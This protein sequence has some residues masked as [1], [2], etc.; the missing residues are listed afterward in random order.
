MPMT[1]DNPL[2]PSPTR[3]R[4]SP[5]GL[6]VVLALAGLEIACG[7]DFT[8][9]PEGDLATS[10][11]SG[12]GDPSSSTAGIS[13]VTGQTGDESE[14]EGDARPPGDAP[15]VIAAFTI[16]GAAGPVTVDHAHTATLEVSAVD[17]EAIARVRLYEGDVALAVVDA[18]PY[19][20]EWAID[21]ITAAA[22]RT[23]RAIAED[24]RGQASAPAEIEVDFSM[25]TPG[26]DRWRDLLGSLHAGE[27][28]GLVRSGHQ[29]IAVGARGFDPQAAE[30][31]AFLRFY[32]ADTGAM[33]GSAAYPKPGT[34]ATYRANAAV[35]TG[36]GEIAVVG[37]GTP[38]EEATRPWLAVFAPNGALL[39]E[40]LDPVAGGEA[41]A[42][43]ADAG[44]L[45]V[46]GQ[47]GDG[48][49]F[50]RRHDL[51][52]APSWAI[53]DDD[54]THLSSELRGLVRGDDGD[55]YVAGT[56]LGAA[57][58]PRVFAGRYGADGS[59][60]WSGRIECE[61]VESD[62]GRAIALGDEG[63]VLIAAAMATDAGDRIELRWIDAA[64]GEH[65]GVSLLPSPLTLGDEVPNAVVVDRRG[66]VYVSATTSSGDGADA[67][68]Y[69]RS[70]DG[71]AS[72]WERS[73]DGADHSDDQALALAVGDDGVVYVG[74]SL[75]TAGWRR[76]WVQALEP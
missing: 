69:K 2:A 43:V 35:L 18:P 41:H 7:P 60:R 54:P 12:D 36:A 40:R 32:D 46:A 72:M 65:R 47:G 9:D 63:D 44:G 10:S 55:L 39:R 31:H 51:D 37:V 59:V 4:R 62:Q 42:V 50:L 27:V 76:W 53:G 17:D 71:G 70:T 13:T 33:T 56:V 29:L 68:V 5:R 74:G 14:S 49:L 64:A 58:P 3:S 66:R 8:G 23:L 16:D 11:T 61:G 6:F 25:A 73:I 57:I 24:A 1:I 22:P 21:D 15:P 67:V 45:Y 30:T 20:F 28:R 34:K 26:A 48:L 38:P 75:T 52:L 19:R